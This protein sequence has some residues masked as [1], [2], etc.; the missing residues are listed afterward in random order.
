MKGVQNTTNILS[1]S[2]P[3]ILNFAP[4]FQA[5]GKYKFRI[6]PPP[7]KKKAGIYT[8]Y[9][10]NVFNLSSICSPVIPMDL[11]VIEG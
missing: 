10:L 9:I 3:K 11:N 6:S 8:D 5:P 1:T 7:L 2:N 4:L